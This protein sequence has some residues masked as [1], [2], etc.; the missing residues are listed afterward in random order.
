MTSPAGGGQGQVEP[1]THAQRPAARLSVPSLQPVARRDFLFLCGAPGFARRRRSAGDSETRSLGE[2]RRRHSRRPGAVG[3]QAMSG[4]RQVPSGPRPTRAGT[5]LRCPRPPPPQ[6]GAAAPLPDPGAGIQAGTHPG[7]HPLGPSPTRAGHYPARTHP[8]PQ[9]PRAQ[10][11][12]PHLPG[13]PQSAQRAFA[14]RCS[15]SS[16]AFRR[17][18]AMAALPPPATPGGERPPRRARAPRRPPAAAAPA[19]S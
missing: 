17:S 8:D 4:S 1:H 15:S 10:P 11:A 16:T 12:A 2:G 9:L 19:P 6:A 3:G 7:P 13:A 14:G 5:R 18:L